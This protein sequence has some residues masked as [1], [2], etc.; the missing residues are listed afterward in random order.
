M[1]IVEEVPHIQNVAGQGTQ[2]QLSSTPYSGV[3]GP[4][5][6]ASVSELSRQRVGVGASEH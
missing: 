6:T 4:P 2:T 1:D 5:G 3:T